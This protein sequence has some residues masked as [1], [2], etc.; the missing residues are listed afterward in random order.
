MKI[1]N[2]K[3]M[4]HK[5]TIDLVPQGWTDTSLLAASKQNRKGSMGIISPTNGSLVHNKLVFS[6]SQLT[7]ALVE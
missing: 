1:I 7:T 4:Q 2:K 6:G 3:E 5:N